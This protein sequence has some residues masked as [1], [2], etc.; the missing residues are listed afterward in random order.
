MSGTHLVVFD[1]DGTLTD[2]NAVGAEGFWR[3]TREVL[4]LPNEH[5]QWLEQA[6]HYTDLAMASQHC[7]AA[8]RRDITARCVISDRRWSLYRTL[9]EAQPSAIFRHRGARKLIGIVLEKD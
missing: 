5:S 3:A 7:K 4:S 6:E 1:V 9:L 2:T 8:F